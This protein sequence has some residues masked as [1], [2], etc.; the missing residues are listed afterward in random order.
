MALNLDATPAHINRGIEIEH[1]DIAQLNKD[2]AF[3]R[4]SETETPVL[5]SI[6]RIRIGPHPSLTLQAWWEHVKS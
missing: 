3:P 1:E 2:E 4:V 5:D 6:I